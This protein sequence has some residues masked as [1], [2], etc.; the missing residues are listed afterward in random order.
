MREIPGDLLEVGGLLA[1][2]GC[3]LECHEAGH[4]VREP[5]GFL[6][7]GQK[8]KNG[9]LVVC[10]GFAVDG[11]EEMAAG[12]GKGTP[13]DASGVDL[14]QLLAYDFGRLLLGAL[15]EGVLPFSGRAFAPSEAPAAPI[16]IDARVRIAFRDAEFFPK[17]FHLLFNIH[18]FQ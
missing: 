14:A 13:N 3:G 4:G 1:F 7:A 12:G 17:G 9:V 6:A 15:H 11:F 2:L 8:G 18:C 10:R 16:G 5:A